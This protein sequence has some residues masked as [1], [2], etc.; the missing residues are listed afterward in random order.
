MRL[1]V[2]E[3]NQG[4]IHPLTDHPFVDHEWLFQ[5]LAWPL[6]SLG[7]AAALT[8]VKSLVVLA[9]FALMAAAGRRHGSQLRWVVLTVALVVAGSYWDVE[10]WW[11]VAVLEDNV[12]RFLVPLYAARG[13]IRALA[14]D[15]AAGKSFVGGMFT[16]AG[17]SLT[18]NYVAKWDGTS[19]SALD[20]GMDA[21]VRAL[22]VWDDGSGA[23]LFAGVDFTTAG[24]T[25]ASR[26]AMWDGS[27]WSALGSGTSGTVYS[28]ADFDDGSGAALY[29][30]GNFSTAG[31]TYI[32]RVAKWDGSSWSN[33]GFSPS[34]GPRSMLV[35]DDGGGQATQRRPF[36]RRAVVLVAGLDHVGDDLARGP[37]LGLAG[38]G[39]D[40]CKL[41][42]VEQGFDGELHGQNCTVGGCSAPSTASKYA[43]SEKPK[44]LAM[45]TAGKRRRAV[46]KAWAASL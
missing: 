24:G 4:G 15:S 32:P 27:T 9:T 6:F 13:D 30:G 19:W 36:P 43:F 35:F 2:L 21:P 10:W 18:V 41:P 34:F 39:G 3:W 42:G 37:D 44:R 8:L 7:G 16:T 25:S 22:F 33:P 29:V 5:V 28:F 38:G 31:G 11:Y 45:K 40:G 23:A 12:W 46:L 17:G 14:T 20:T 26:V 1:V